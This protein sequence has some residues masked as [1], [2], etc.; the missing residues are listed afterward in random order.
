M[1]A[2]DISPS[3]LDRA[4]RFSQ[5]LI[6]AL[7]GERIGTIIFAGNAYMQV[8]LTIDYAAANLFISSSNPNMAPSQ[9]TAIVDAIDLA[10]QSFDEDNKNYK[11]LIIISDGE[12]H[13]DEALARA[14]E[15]R[16]NGLLIYTVGV[17][18]TEGS[19]YPYLCRRKTRL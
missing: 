14:K 18:T 7:K 16:A 10:E 8:P 4:K 1:L 6:N 12:N 9:G 15:A 13:D 17:G 3:R 5:N 2:E 19:F 11:A